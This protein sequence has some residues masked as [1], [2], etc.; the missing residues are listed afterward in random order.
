MQFMFAL[1]LAAMLGQAATAASF[2]TVKIDKESSKYNFSV[3]YPEFLPGSAPG[4]KAI[5]ATIYEDI[6]EGG[7]ELDQQITNTFDYSAV[8]EVV[9]L[10]KNYVSVRADTSS[11]CGGAHPNYS[12]YFLTFAAESGALLNIEKEFGFI[13]YNDPGYDHEKTEAR[14]RLLAELLVD[15][16]SSQAKETECF[17]GTRQEM[18]DSLQDFF[19]YV[20]GLASGKKVILAISP[21]HAATP[22]YFDARVDYAA[23]KSLLNADSYLHKWL[24]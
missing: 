4:Y 12:T 6:V 21:P 15:H 3:E 8:A 14:R 20:A 17:T 22:C 13:D 18:I 23:I 5:N 10:N 24:Q 19:P 1:I 2:K 9:A 7:C 11:F 16:N